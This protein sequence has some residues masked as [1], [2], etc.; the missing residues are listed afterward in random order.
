M[1]V[2]I[3]EP[4]DTPHIKKVSGMEQI[5]E[6]I[7]GDIEE[8]RITDNIMILCDEIGRLKELPFCFIW[9]R[10]RFFGTCVFVGYGDG[11][12]LKDFPHNTT[13]DFFYEM[14]SKGFIPA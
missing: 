11:E 12:E 10:V 8:F 1:R 13:E 6:I 4:G 14:L 5:R 2:M 3:K 9:G 7:G